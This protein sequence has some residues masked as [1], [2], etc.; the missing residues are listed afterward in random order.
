MMEF[1]E[2]VIAFSGFASIIRYLLFNFLALC[3]IALA[4]R[5]ALKNEKENARL[6][7]LFAISCGVMGIG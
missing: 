4:G 2:F 7:L 1:I 3:F 5:S 6:F